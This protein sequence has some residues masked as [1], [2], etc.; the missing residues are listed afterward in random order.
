MQQK[1]LQN[2]L[3]KKLINAYNSNVY[4]ERYSIKVETRRADTNN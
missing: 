3:K 2:M 4:A 1:K